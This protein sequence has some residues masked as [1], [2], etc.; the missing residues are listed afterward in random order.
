MVARQ[1]RVLE[2][3]S[4]N[5]RTSTKKEQTAL[6]VVCSFLVGVFDSTQF[7]PRANGVR[8]PNKAV[9]KLAFQRRVKEYCFLAIPPHFDQKAEE[10][11]CGS[12]LFFVGVD[13]E[14]SALRSRMGFAYRTRR[15]TSLLVRRRGRY[16]RVANVSALRP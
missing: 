9:G 3:R 5:L 15:S 14:N 16:L 1:F 7:A 8:I 2:A 4:S 6:A 12:L 11:P 10:S 13:D